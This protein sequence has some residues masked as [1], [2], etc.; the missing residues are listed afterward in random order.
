MRTPAT[1]RRSSF[2]GDGTI[3]S[4]SRTGPPAGAFKGVQFGL[5]E[6]RLG[7]GDL[8]FLYSDGLTEARRGAEFYGEE[9]LF[10]LLSSVDG[11]PQSVIRRVST[12]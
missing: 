12:M 10:A 6:T 8:L 4:L 9:R 1:P 5:A 2:H 3:T 11:G 7:F